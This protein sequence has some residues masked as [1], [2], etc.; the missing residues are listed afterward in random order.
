MQLVTAAFTVV[1]R[2][3]VLVLASV[4][5]YAK[6]EDAPRL[7]AHDRLIVDRQRLTTKLIP[8]FTNHLK[9]DDKQS[10][11]IS[12]A[13]GKVLE[14]VPVSYESYTPRAGN[15]AYRCGIFFFRTN[16]DPVFVPTIGYD[17]TEPEMCGELKAVGF[18]PGGEGGFPRV[19]LIYFA[20]TG[21]WSGLGSTVLDYSL[22]EGRYRVNDNVPMKPDG[23]GSWS[24]EKVK[25]AIRRAA[26]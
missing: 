25:A 1:Y 19:L 3:S 14:M 15:T 5:L 2:T 9:T 6:A 21:N 4:S 12:G 11:L 18:M 13:T 17:N 26:P 10:F 16:T 8:N 7:L 24:I 22:A 20:G 23:D